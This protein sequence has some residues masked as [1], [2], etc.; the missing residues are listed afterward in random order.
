MGRSVSRVGGD[1]QLRAYRAVAGNLRL[2]Y[3]QFNELE[4]FS[5]FATQLDEDTR[6]TLAHGRRVRE[7]LKQPQF[8]PRDV[9][10][11]VAVLLAVSE[12]LFDDVPV[13][14]VGH[15]AARVRSAMRK[16]EELASRIR[17]DQPLED[18]DRQRIRELGRRA[19]AG[20]RES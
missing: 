14:D 5:R 1:A 17:G 3:S 20:V 13:E 6:R 11:Q 10:E 9:P 19:A 7:I 12:G 8:E 2:A 18:D 15:V 4:R 16:E